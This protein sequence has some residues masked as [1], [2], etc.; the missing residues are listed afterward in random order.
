M[1]HYMVSYIMLQDFLQGVT[2]LVFP[3]NCFLCRKYLNNSHQEQ[4]CPNCWQAVVAN[5][6]PFCLKCSRHLTI[7]NDQ[8]LCASC[9]KITPS[10]DVAW[11]ACLYEQP[12]TDLIHS[13]KYYGKT[14]LKK[15]LS[16]LMINFVETYQIP[17]DNFDVVV[18]IPLHPARYRERGFN[19]AELLSQIISSHCHLTHRTDILS[20]WKFTPSQT[21]QEA[22]QRWT[23]MHD[24]FR[25]NNFQDVADKSILIVDDLL[26]TAATTDAA[27]K[28]LKNTG[29][30][31]VGV[32][33]LAITP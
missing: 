20:R 31:Y 33:T 11:S 28:A 30:A 24:A 6:P 18:P 5:T 9:L 22:K 14:A 3:D 7:F 10:F 27:S 23:N 26:T 12:L 4:L 19:Q 15:T 17:L 32:L 1:V 25:I 29:A 16:Q 21:K 2:E 8:G 13:F